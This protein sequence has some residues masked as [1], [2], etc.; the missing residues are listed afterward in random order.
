MRQLGFGHARAVVT[1]VYLPLLFTRF[2]QAQLDGAA[3][4]AVGHGVAQHIV[5]RTVEITGIAQHLC[6][7]G[8]AALPL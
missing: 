5:K 6:C 4:G 2:A 3:F 8:Y 7:F 1:D